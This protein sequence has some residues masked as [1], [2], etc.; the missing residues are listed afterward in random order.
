MRRSADD[1]P[2]RPLRHTGESRYPEDPRHSTATATVRRAHDAP[3]GNAAYL[4]AS[5]AHRHAGAR[6]CP[7]ECLGTRPFLYVCLCWG[8]SG[9]GNTPCSPGGGFRALHPTFLRFLGCQ[10]I[11]KVAEA[12]LT[13]LSYRKPYPAHGLRLRRPT[14]QFH[15]L[16]VPGVLERD[17]G[18]PFIMQRIGG[19]QPL[20]WG[21][22]WCTKQAGLK[23]EIQGFHDSSIRFV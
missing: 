15:R 16:G 13:F 8:A 12:R 7:V 19:V 22:G 18:S 5:L 9:H 21:F 11:D 4:K 3:F 2:L 20:T 10:L 6:W 23:S 17:T 1:A 14:K